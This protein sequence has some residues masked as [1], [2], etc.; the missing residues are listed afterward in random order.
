MNRP[1]SIWINCAV[2]WND[3][4]LWQVVTASGRLI[5]IAFKWRV[6]CSPWVLLIE[7]EFLAQRW[8]TTEVAE[9]SSGG[10]LSFIGTINEL[11]CDYSVWPLT[12]GNT[13]ADPLKNKVVGRD[14]KKVLWLLKLFHKGWSYQ[15]EGFYMYNTES[16]LSYVVDGNSGSRKPRLRPWG[17]V[18]LTTQ[19][20]LSAK[21]GTNFAGRLRSLARSV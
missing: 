5:Y 4:R 20:P 18:A 21:V 10:H 13:R 9:H 3:R 19:H 12:Y 16:Y 14:G 7:A 11:S 1:R 15:A 6:Y 17:S 8:Q 2:V